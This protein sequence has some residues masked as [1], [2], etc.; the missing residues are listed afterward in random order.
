MAAVTDFSK[1]EPPERRKKPTNT[2]MFVKSACIIWFKVMNDAR[3][4]YTST[5]LNRYGAIISDVRHNAKYLH[6]AVGT[7]LVLGLAST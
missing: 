1:F 2:Q 7:T 4:E 5:K 3:I 6:I